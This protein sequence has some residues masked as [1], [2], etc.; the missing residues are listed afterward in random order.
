M[1]SR[2]YHPYH[3]W[4]DYRAGMYGTSEYPI[5]HEALSRALLAAPASLLQAM[6]C[7]A[8]AWLRAAEHRLTAVGE[9]RRAWLGAAACCHRYGAP[10]HATRAAWW[11]LN[12]AQKAAANVAADVVIAEWENLRSGVGTLFPADWM[13]SNA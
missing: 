1:S 6:R 5:I 3:E 4:E 8:T 13:A 9:N 7:A 2:I 12:E 11:T 10:E